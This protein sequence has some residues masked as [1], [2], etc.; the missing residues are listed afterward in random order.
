MVKSDV[1][2]VLVELGIDAT[3]RGMDEWVARCPSHSPDRSPS[4]VIIDDPSSPRHGLM[5]CWSCGFQGT[6]AL[7]VMHVRGFAAWSSAYELLERFPARV[8]PLPMVRVGVAES[9]EFR[10]PSEVIWE[11]I[12]SWP[13]AIRDY[14]A[15]RGITSQQVGR[16]GI[17]YAVDGG[18]A[19][20]IVIPVHDSRGRLCSYQ[21]RLVPGFGDGPRYLTPRELDH[22]D[23]D[24]VFGEL[25]WPAQPRRTRRVTV[26]E[27]AIK[28]LAFE[29]AV[30]EP[31]AVLGGSKIRAAHADKLAS[32]GEVL[33][34]TDN[35]GSGEEVAEKI[36]AILGRHSIV[37]RVILPR[38]PDE[39]DPG[40]VAER[41]R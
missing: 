37:K 21:A 12:E 39:M 9:R 15:S 17:G 33:I 27:G 25:C 2:A 14:A 40:D 26:W 18:L 20:R 3:R 38:D 23:N 32:F 11:P 36:A 1:G 8:Q 6:L 7:L 34:A 22:P 31:F 30:P 16:W 28:A 19:G 41:F 29:R 24:A 35:D 13:R 4:W 5:K 10:V